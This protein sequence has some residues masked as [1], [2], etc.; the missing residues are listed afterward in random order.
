MHI[1]LPTTSVEEAFREYEMALLSLQRMLTVCLVIW[2][3]TFLLMSF[4]LNDLPLFGL[5]FVAVAVYLVT[6]QQG[7]DI[8]VFLGSVALGKGTGLLLVGRE[9]H[10]PSLSEQTEK[11]Q[12]RLT[13]TATF[14]TSLVILLALSS[15]WH[16]DMTSNHYH[17]PRWMGLWN[18]PNDYGLL[19]GVGAILA[20]ALP[21]LSLKSKVKRQ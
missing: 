5:L 14:L 6:P 11:Y 4:G 7:T 12:S 15:F 1:H 17:G 9:W 8:L 3:G 16:L 10:E 13:S 21:V 20:I 18:N 2:S 19:M